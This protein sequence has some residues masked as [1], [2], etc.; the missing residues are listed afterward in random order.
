MPSQ[1]LCPGCE[2][3]LPWN[4]H[5]CRQCAAP[6]ADAAAHTLCGQCLQ[7]PPVWEAAASPLRYAWPLDGLI[8]RFKFAADLRTGRMLGNLLAAFLAA[9]GGSPRPDCL[10]PVP[11]HASR[12]KARGF[13]QALELAR[14]VSRRLRV[15]LANGLCQRTRATD[16]Q[17]RLPAAARA[18]TLRGAFAVSNAVAGLRI[19]IVDDVVTTGSTVS[20]LAETLRGAGA[21]HIRVWSLARAAP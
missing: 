14:P 15:P 16:T 4:R 8:Q 10:I 1:G 5:A 2:Y 17:S 19:A 9:D 12:L 3:D 11:L 18:R 20:A 13:N 7:R 6:L 21:A